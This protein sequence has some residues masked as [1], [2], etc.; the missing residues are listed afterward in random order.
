MSSA[1][2]N[3]H[4]DNQI[5]DNGRKGYMEDQVLG[6]EPPTAIEQL[7]VD[8]AIA[9]SLVPEKSNPYDQ[10]FGTSL[11]HAQTDSSVPFGTQDS[12]LRATERDTED[13]DLQVALL[14]DSAKQPQQSQAKGDI[15][16]VPSYLNVGKSDQT[17]DSSPRKTP[18]LVGLPLLNATNADTLV[19]M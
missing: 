14:H 1:S 11:A 16:L 13:R 3:G 4:A 10:S 5:S 18:N 19:F 7:H 17:I 8:N 15:S 6:D 2:V 9:A 12:T